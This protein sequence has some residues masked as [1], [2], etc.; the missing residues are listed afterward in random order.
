M[1]QS[2]HTLLLAERRIGKTSM[3]LAVLDRIRDAGSGW[4]LEADLSRGPIESSGELADRLADQARVAGVRIGARGKTTH[5]IRWMTK[6][7]GSQSVK[8]AAR[9]LGMDELSDAAEIAAVVDQT[10]APL[11]EN[12][13]D[14]RAVLRAIQA[15]AAAA[16]RPTVIF[17]DEAQRLCTHWESEADSLDAQAAIAEAMESPDG[18][19]VLLLAGSERTAMETLLAEGTPMHYD[20]M[21][22]DV[23][24]IADADWHHDLPLRFAEVELN[25][26][27]EQ[28]EHIV[29]A[30][31]G[32]PQRTMRVCA[33]VQQLADGEHF[34]I[35]E[36]L[37]GQAI[38]RAREHPSWPT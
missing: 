30:S 32:H 16:D 31:N 19:I 25:I 38:A 11:A 9:A 1:E 15:A 23:P 4:G 12:S 2:Q 13:Q 7:A 36:V 17:L 18:R 27:P 33:H 37:V 28:I 24:P 34:E 21:G 14:L 5:R 10:L 6:I 3:A 22:F 8:A 26:E 29:T 20:G 35:S